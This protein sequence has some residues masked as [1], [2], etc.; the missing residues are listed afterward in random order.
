MRRTKWNLNTDV[1]V[2]C[3]C[4]S[5]NFRRHEQDCNRS[6]RF[7]DPNSNEVFLMPLCVTFL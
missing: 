4:G 3:Q 7:V 2:L 1:E 6:T 5:Q